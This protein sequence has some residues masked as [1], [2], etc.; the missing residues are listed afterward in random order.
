[1]HEWFAQPDPLIS[2]N[3]PSSSDQA[4]VFFSLTHSPHYLNTKNGRLVEPPAM[5]A[6]NQAHSFNPENRSLPGVL[7]GILG[8]PDVEI[9]IHTAAAL[10]LT[11]ELRRVRIG[12]RTGIAAGINEIN[13]PR[14]GTTV[15]LVG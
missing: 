7:P 6:S 5:P 4:S 10:T 13:V 3:S 9:T 8:R 15:D 14:A 11:K 1:M 12:V 2:S